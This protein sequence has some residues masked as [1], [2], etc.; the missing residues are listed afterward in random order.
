MGFA[1]RLLRIA[2]RAW[3]WLRRGID[4]LLPCRFAILVLGL[5]TVIL[6]LTDQGLESLRVMAEFGNSDQVGAREP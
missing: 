2:R 4:T 6:A 5:V 1:K 3:V